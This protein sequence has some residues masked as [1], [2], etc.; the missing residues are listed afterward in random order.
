MK[1]GKGI[2]WLVLVGFFALLFFQNKEFFLERQVLQLNLAVAGRYQTPDL[3]IALFFI[4]F[5][6][7]GFLTA[8]FF[9][10]YAKFKSNQTIKSLT[11]KQTFH[12]ES[13]SKLNA[14][15]ESLKSALER[16]NQQQGPAVV[17]ESLSVIPDEVQKPEE[18]E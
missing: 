12:L 17:E 15:I 7:L 4:V 11:A 2:F 18:D 14:E 10:L 1:K 5:T 9:G 13:I 8:Y 16:K 3:P 6:L